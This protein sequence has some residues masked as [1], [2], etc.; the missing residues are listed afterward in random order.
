MLA[1]GLVFSLIG[2]LIAGLA[3]FSASRGYPELAALLAWTAFGFFFG[4]LAYVRERPQMFGKGQDG[5]LGRV[6]TLLCLPGLALNLLRWWIERK[7]SSEPVTNEVAP[8]LHVGGLPAPA[9]LPPGTR[10]IVDLT[11][12]FYAHPRISEHP[13][14]RNYPMLDDSFVEPNELEAIVQTLLT[15]PT[16][17]LVHCAAGHSRSASL[18]AALGIARGDFKDVEAAERAMQVARPRIRYTSVQ[19]ERLTRWWLEHHGQRSS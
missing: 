15:A 3:L 13:G 1:Y 4:A 9:D 19:R 11:C 17:I 12:E 16:P 7:L 10:T 14:Y 2:S 8:G 18:A 6:V 5:R